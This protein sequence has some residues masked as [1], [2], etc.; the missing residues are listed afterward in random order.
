MINAKLEFDLAGKSMNNTKTRARWVNEEDCTAFPTKIWSSG[1]YSEAINETRDSAV[2]LS[3]W[4]TKRLLLNVRFPTIQFDGH[5]SWSSCI[6]RNW[7]IHCDWHEGCDSSISVP[8]AGTDVPFQAHL[9]GTDHQLLW[10]GTELIDSSLVPFI[11]V[12]ELEL[13]HP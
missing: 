2:H 9:K 4:G 13:S 10:V 12:Y 8:R 1:C 7:L 5:C 6:H 11:P 3:V